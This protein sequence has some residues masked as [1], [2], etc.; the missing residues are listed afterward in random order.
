MPPHHCARTPP[1]RRTD[2][3]LTAFSGLNAHYTLDAVAAE[4]A[5][6]RAA[7]Q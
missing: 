1:E 2:R 5:L 4:F 6:L 3:Y 7:T